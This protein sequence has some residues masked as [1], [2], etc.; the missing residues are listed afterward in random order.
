[1]IQET[2]LE[3]WKDIQENLGQ[4]QTEVLKCI[5]EQTLPI[6]NRLIAKE[7]NKPINCITPRVNELVKM[8]LIEEKFKHRDKETKKTTIFWGT[9]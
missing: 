4:K 1:M 6:N 9:K 3:A 8:G 5:K 7:L 2:S